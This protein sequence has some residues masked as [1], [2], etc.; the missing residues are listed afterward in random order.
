[1]PREPLEPQGIVVV[2]FITIFILIAGLGE[3]ELEVLAERVENVLAGLFIDNLFIINYV[4]HW[5]FI[6]LAEREKVSARVRLP[7]TY[8]NAIAGTYTVHSSSSI[9]RTHTFSSSTEKLFCCL[10]TYVRE[11]RLRTRRHRQKA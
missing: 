4:I 5:L 2:L 9:A 8:K 7:Y 10:G 3:D 11:R 1:M 6:Y